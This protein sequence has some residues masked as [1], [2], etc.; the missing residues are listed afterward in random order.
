M[1]HGYNDGEY[2]WFDEAVK[3]TEEEWKIL[4]K[5]VK[6][7][8]DDWINV[9]ENRMIDGDNIYDWTELMDNK[10]IET[11][12]FDLDEY[13]CQAAETAI[14]HEALNNIYPPM[15][16]AAE[17]GEV[18]GKYAKAHRDGANIDREA[19]ILELGDVLWF[20]A[21]IATDLDVD[22]SEVAEANIQK[23]RSRKERGVIGGAGDYR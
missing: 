10:T 15:G 7:R 17:A 2:T 16:L 3:M 19:I 20:V 9:K 13:Q 18:A 11:A 23:L 6:D 5:K 8:R 14:Y 21:A 1:K 4:D 12:V 22:L